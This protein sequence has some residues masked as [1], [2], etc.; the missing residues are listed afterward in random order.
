MNLW[1]RRV[2]QGFPALNNNEHETTNLTRVH[3]RKALFTRNAG[4]KCRASLTQSS[5]GDGQNVMRRLGGYMFSAPHGLHN[6]LVR[7]NYLERTQA[8]RGCTGRS[9][10]FPCKDMPHCRKLLQLSNLMKICSAY[11]GVFLAG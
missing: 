11:M 3:L 9:P 8:P 7:S 10:Y 1:A 6:E 2:P 4:T 5:L